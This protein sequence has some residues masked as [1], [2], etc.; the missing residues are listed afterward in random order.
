M[1]ARKANGANAPEDDSHAE[2]LDIADE[3]PKKA[4]SADLV[5]SIGYDPSRRSGNAGRP[6]E[7][8]GA[9][10][11]IAK[12]D[13]SV[14]LGPIPGTKRIR[15]NVTSNFAPSRPKEENKGLESDSDSELEIES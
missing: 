9:R 10:Q 2:Q 12:A 15:S 11:L 13:R 5:K 4:Y 1:K 3:A 8:E 14:D 6:K 7:G